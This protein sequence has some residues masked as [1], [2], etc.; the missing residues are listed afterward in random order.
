MFRRK[1]STDTIP[2]D[3]RIAQLHYET[4]VRD[5]ASFT[6]ATGNGPDAR[7]IQQVIE[8]GRAAGIAPE[9]LAR[10][11]DTMRAWGKRP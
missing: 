5:H 11:A 3:Q 9:Q 1:Q 2:T 4:S 10:D 8:R 7:E 6:L